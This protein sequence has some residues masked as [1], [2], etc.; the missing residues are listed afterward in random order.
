MLA[1]DHVFCLVAP[2]GDW[3]GRFAA[4]GWTLDDGSVH[5]GQ[6][7]RNRRL[8]W[9]GLF[10]EMLW[11][12][13]VDEARHNALRLDRRAEWARTGASPFGIGLR[14]RPAEA[15]LPDY[16]RYDGLPMPVWVHRDNEE[17][18]ERPLVFAVEPSEELR[19]SAAL[20]AP[21]NPGSLV[22]VRHFG[23]AAARLPGY[24]GPEVR[25]AAGPHRLELVVD[26]GEPVAVTRELVLTSGA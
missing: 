18:P 6:G 8:R 26:G 4:A 2:D 20:G 19:R 9:V 14:G 21:V 5:A 23:P 3:A 13:D 24:S 12:H 10:L 11:V 1:F 22:A 7:T 16:W 17:A 15:D 25:H